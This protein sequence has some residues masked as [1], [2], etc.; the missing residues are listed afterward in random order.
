MIWNVGIDIR[1]S[2]DNVDEFSLVQFLDGDSF[3]GSQ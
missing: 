2:V 1:I 3:V